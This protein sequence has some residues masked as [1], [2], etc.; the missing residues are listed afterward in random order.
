MGEDY[1]PKNDRI[2]EFNERV[3]RDHLG[4][5]VRSTVEETLNWMLKQIGF[6]MRRSISEQR[7]APTRVQG[8]MSASCTPRQVK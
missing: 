3:I 4:E 1:T 7:H 5:M 2:I 6:V 8:I